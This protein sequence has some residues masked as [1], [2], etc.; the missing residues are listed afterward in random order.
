[1]SK[2]VTFTNRPGNNN[3]EIFT[4]VIELSTSIHQPI[5]FIIEKE[6]SPLNIRTWLENAGQ[7]E[8][9]YF[10]SRDNK[11]E[12]GAF[13]TAFT[14]S[15]EQAE[16]LLKLSPQENLV[17][18]FASCFSE[19]KKIDDVWDGIPR[20]LCFVPE[21]MIRRLDN[22]YV[23]QYCMVIDSDSNL[24]ILNKVR[25]DHENIFTGQ[26]KPHSDDLHD[27]E[28]QQYLPDKNKW[29][30]II[31]KCLNSIDSG[32][33]NKI[34]IS[35]RIDYQTESAI[36]PFD[37]LCSIDNGQKNN[38]AMLFQNKE[39]KSF[40]SVSPE[41]L[42]RREKRKISV[43]ALSSTVERGES[44]S[45]DKSLERQ[46]FNDNKLQREHQAVIDGVSSSLE[47][48]C[49]GQLKMESSKVLKLSRIQHLIALI[50]GQLKENISDRKIIETLHPTPAVGG[51]PRDD[52]V[53]MIS[54]LEPFDRGWYAGP[55]GY[56]GKKE[57]EIVIGIRSLLIDNKRAHVFVG[58]GIV[59]GSN[60]EDE[61]NETESKNPLN[62]FIAHTKI[63]I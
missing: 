18:L 58:S 46:L 20:T 12:L 23:V 43:D 16:E 30:Q 25:T 8:K 26:K 45:E 4:N 53:D 19:S 47:L 35:R 11:R 36:N 49:D 22:K 1:M 14:A 52:A 9:F 21:I 48:L 42:Y 33:I 5:P 7:G 57:S 59:E 3:T 61:W 32:E 62:S 34:V 31:S 15:P 38:F 55:I 41:R 24:E 56:W 37:L 27:F 44:E 60:P 39:G 17:F 6:I 10:Q 54:K 51:T 63:K 40:I 13:K 29:N 2:K 28:H 50:S